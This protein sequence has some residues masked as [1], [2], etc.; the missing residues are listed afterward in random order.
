ME[1]VCTSEMSFAVLIPLEDSQIC[2]GVSSEICTVS[3]L[4]ELFAHLRPQF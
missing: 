1:V 3:Q 2:C 4:S